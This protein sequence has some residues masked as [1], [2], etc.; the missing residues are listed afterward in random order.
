MSTSAPQIGVCPLGLDFGTSS[1]LAA[2]CDL[3]FAYIGP[4]AQ[5]I[6]EPTPR[7]CRAVTRNLPTSTH[8]NPAETKLKLRSLFAPPDVGITY[9]DLRLTRVRTGRRE[10]SWK[11]RSSDAQSIFG[12]KPF[13]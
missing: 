5:Q 13:K 3:W 8:Q 11:A 4:L 10:D 2:G 12:S 9:L 1:R 7:A 6:A